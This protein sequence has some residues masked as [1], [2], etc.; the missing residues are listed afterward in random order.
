LIYNDGHD[1]RF[2]NKIKQETQLNNHYGESTFACFFANKGSK[3]PIYE[4]FDLLKNKIL[5]LISNRSS[6]T[7]LF[8][9]INRKKVIQLLFF[10]PSKLSNIIIFF[11]HIRISSKIQNKLLMFKK[12]YELGF[13]N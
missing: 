12:I 4:I 2:E 8:I 9:K 5:Y 11:L 10:F 1:L 13:K 3:R 7:Y 6:V